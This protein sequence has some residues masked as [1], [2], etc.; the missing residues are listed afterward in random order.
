MIINSTTIQIVTYSQPNTY[1]VNK[2]KYM[3]NL[4]AIK[5]DLTNVSTHFKQRA[6][7]AEFQ[8]KKDLIKEG[9]GHSHSQRMNKVR[10]HR[11]AKTTVELP[12]TLIGYLQ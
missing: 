5:L 7:E 12:Y 2:I 8:G 6:K 4:V 10:A 11:T 1:T 3:K 9:S